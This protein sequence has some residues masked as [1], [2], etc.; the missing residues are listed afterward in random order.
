MSISTEE[1]KEGYKKLTNYFE[2]EQIGFVLCSS[3]IENESNWPSHST[4]LSC[5]NAIIL[6][7]NTLVALV[8]ASYSD[9]VVSGF[10]SSL[11]KSIDELVSI[12]RHTEALK[13][14]SKAST[15][16]FSFKERGE[17]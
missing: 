8:D 4:N 15:S 13:K 5:I 2:Q 6:L 17:A 1:F 16:I 3:A 7:S 12:Y 14:E 10:K 11:D 9:E